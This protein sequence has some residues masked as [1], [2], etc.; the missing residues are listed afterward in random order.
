MD[1]RRDVISLAEVQR[2]EA[3]RNARSAADIA[4]L[5]MIDAAS[6]AGV[7]VPARVWHIEGLLPAHTVTGLSGDGATGKST[8]ALQ[9]ALAT[10]TGGYWFGLPA[11][12]GPCIYLTAEDGL[13]EVHRRLDAILDAVN[14]TFAELEGRGLKIVP[15]ADRDALLAVP[16]TRTG[17][18]RPTDLFR[19]FDRRV[20]EVRPALVLLDTKA[21]LFGGDENNRAHARQFV[22]ILRAQAIRHGTTH[23]LLDHPSLGGMASGTGTSGSTGWSNSVRSRL[24]FERVKDGDGTEPD[25]DARLLRVMKSNY[26]RSGAEMR[27]RWDGGMFKLAS[28]AGGS[29][30]T[31]YAAQENAERVFLEMLA[32]YEAEGR[33]VAAAGPTYAPTLFAKDTRADGLNRRGLADAMNRLFKAK[34]IRVEE[35]GPASRRRS[36]I[37]AVAGG[38]GE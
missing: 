21:D 6:F 12:E 9:L 8:I 26:A 32:A 25:V 38:E 29:T 4:P 22:G 16:D 14:I 18:L 11:L 34:R 5:E 1:M 23:L 2:E 31:A 13:D 37:V 30:F 36:R 24:Y 28:S 15:V 33:N 10:V 17:A 35:F 20:A 7:P 3:E 19:A 27:I